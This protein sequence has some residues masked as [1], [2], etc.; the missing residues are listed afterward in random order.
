MK[1]EVLGKRKDSLLRKKVKWA[2]RGG[3]AL[4]VDVLPPDG[5]SMDIVDSQQKSGFFQLGSNP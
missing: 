3:S 1:R 2:D 5:G 4:P